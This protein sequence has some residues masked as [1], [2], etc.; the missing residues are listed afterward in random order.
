[1]RQRK[2]F[3]RSL[4]PRDYLINKV[5]K[6][7]LRKLKDADVDTILPTER[8]H[9]AMEKTIERFFRSRRTKWH[10][11]QVLEQCFVD[12]LKRMKKVEGG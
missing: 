11:M 9:F 1:M 10:G 7:D 8:S 2:Y 3:L 12:E 6:F 5:V 4:S